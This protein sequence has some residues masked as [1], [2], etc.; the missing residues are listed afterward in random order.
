MK[1][2]HYPAS[3]KVTIELDIDHKWLS[4][5]NRLGLNLS[6]LLEESLHRLSSDSYIRIL[7]AEDINPETYQRLTYDFPVATTGLRHC[8]H[9]K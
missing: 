8:F 4:M 7:T 3:H 9:D 6:E 2:V 5:V 1:T